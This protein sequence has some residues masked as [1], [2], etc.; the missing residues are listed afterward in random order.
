MHM[1]A[2][3]IP[4]RAA[5]MFVAALLAGTPLQAQSSQQ[6]VTVLGHQEQAPLT[7]VVAFGDLALTTRV[8]RSALV[9]RVSKAV[10]EVCPNA[11]YAH[12]V[13]DLDYDA[14]DCVN[15]AWAGANAQIR[16]AFALARSGQAV[17]MAI[18]VTGARS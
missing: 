6:P 12:S 10:G 14:E 17:A 18:E 16:R 3:N 13:Y 11:A 7:R 1:I 4:S 8:G 15:F 2:S 5:V 9:S